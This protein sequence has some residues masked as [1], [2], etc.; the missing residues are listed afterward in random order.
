MFLGS[1][2]PCTSK[3]PAPRQFQCDRHKLPYQVFTTTLL[4]CPL[5]IRKMGFSDTLNSLLFI[6]L[7]LY[8]K[9]SHLR[10]PFRYSEN[11][12]HTSGK[13]QMLVSS[14]PSPLFSWQSH[15]VHT[16]LQLTM[17]LWL[18]LN[19]GSSCFCL[20][21]TEIIGLHHYTWLYRNKLHPNGVSLCSSGVLQPQVPKTRIPCV[22]HHAII[23]CQFWSSNGALCDC[24]A[25]VSF[26]LTGTNP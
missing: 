4:Y 22:C 13:W 26:T 9:T 15:I 7:I 10:G 6:S 5:M 2:L 3:A 11:K 14:V 1:I 8:R 24:S 25:L 12:V 18:T 16:G 23:P 19:S 21:S 20:P 17:S